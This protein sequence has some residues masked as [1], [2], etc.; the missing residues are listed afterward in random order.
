MT[1]VLAVALTAAA[2]VATRTGSVDRWWYLGYVRA[3]IDGPLTAREP[4]L[5]TG[6]VQPRFAFHTWL[7]AL[8]VWARLSGLDPL[9][10]FDRACPAL[11]MPVAFAA[12]AT[13]GR[14]LFRTSR[15]AW[16]TA[17]C[18]GLLWA[19]GG[20]V[21]ALTRLPE[22]KILAAVVLSPILWAFGIRACERSGAWTI[23][24]AA[25]AV[26]I[27]TIHPLGFL[28]SAGPL[29]A[30]CVINARH[31]PPLRSA[32]AAVALVL[33]VA[34]AYP[35]VSGFVVRRAYVADGAAGLGA[36]HPVARVHRARQ[37]LVNVGRLGY[38]VDPHLLAHPIRWIA[39]AALPLLWRRSSREAS[40]LAPAALIPLAVAFVPPLS[41]AAGAV[42]LPWMLHR[43][44]WSIP[45]TALAAVTVDEGSRRLGGR[46]GLI[47]LVLLVL[48]V[49]WARSAATERMREEREALAVPATPQLHEALAAVRALPPNAILAAA[50][51][52]S[53]RLPGLT[54]VH[55]LAMSD[56]AT[57][58]FAGTR[59][60]GET[61]LRERAAIFAGV[62]EAVDDAPSPSHVLFAPGAATSRYC[63]SELLRNEQFVLCRFS[64]ASAPS[65]TRMPEVDA[66]EDGEERVMAASLLATT[67]TLD[68]G[69]PQDARRAS[70]T[71][72]CE[73]KPGRGGKSPGGLT[74]PRPGPWS[75]DF[76]TLACSFERAT[77]LLPRTLILEPAI[78]TAVEELMIQVTGLAPENAGWHVHA[79]R[80]AHDGET[81]RF[82]LPREAVTRL[83]IEI[84]PSFLPFVKL[85]R[86]ELTLG[87]SQGQQ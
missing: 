35:L 41:T 51:E 32:I 29:A 64:P 7:G 45:F 71:A 59:A 73:P 50:P 56:R 24:T 76:P 79:R 26:A 9:W 3:W 6:F 61:R 57:V 47:A 67:A 36:D 22:D 62:W 15:G 77:G 5:G 63:G 19:G 48:C 17:L 83:T 46:T 4:F 68:V 8:A 49:P 11:L 14:A 1:L 16:L 66:A 38:V 31:E 69:A 60:A 55:V 23:A 54:G 74:R 84:T 21:A 28:L 2:V 75:A 80:R 13:L 85:D 20:L 33:V 39:L 87:G 78:G 18:A 42:I 70:I 44:L 58:V 43:V 37:R 82:A 81:L 53:E 27:A 52:L 25:A 34:S 40:F 72:R 10:L 65:G 86:F 12:H 30:Y